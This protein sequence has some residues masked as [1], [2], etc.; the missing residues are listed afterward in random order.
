MRGRQLAHPERSVEVMENFFE[1]VQDVAQIEKEP[2][3]E[4][5]TIAMTIAP[6]KKK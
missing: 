6:I 3:R 4:G 1:L 5:R 2:N